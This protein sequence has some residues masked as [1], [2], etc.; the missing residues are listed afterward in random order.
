MQ[1]LGKLQ[2]NFLR[3]TAVN[4][5]HENDFE[6]AAMWSLYLKSNEGI[7]IQTTFSK[8]KKSIIDKET[9]YIGR[10]RY[11]DYEN[12]IIESTYNF[13]NSVLLKRKS[14]EH[15]R[16]IR[17]VVVKWPIVE[18]NDDESPSASPNQEDNNDNLGKMD[19]LGAPSTVGNGIEIQVD[20]DELV[21]NI[22]IAPSAPYWFLN[23]VKNVCIKYGYDFNITKS[24][25]N[26][27][28]IY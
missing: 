8:L 5:W 2:K 20:V 15:E 21:E 26:D 9:V 7:A 3:F 14:Y 12:E 27:S 24:S 13:F 17:A 28:P 23:V 1:S 4:C 10:I 11:I 19:L 16:E 22:F 18:K 6:S 25:L